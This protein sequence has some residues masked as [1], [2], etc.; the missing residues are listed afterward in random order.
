MDLM[1]DLFLLAVGF[2]CGALT[3]KWSRKPRKAEP[4]IIHGFNLSHSQRQYIER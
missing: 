3:A 2:I 4:T 1:G